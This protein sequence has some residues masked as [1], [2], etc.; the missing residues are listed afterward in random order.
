MIQPGNVF[1]PCPV[2]TIEV[3]MMCTGKHST[4]QI[5]QEV[6]RHKVSLHIFN[7]IQVLLAT[8]DWTDFTHC[9]LLTPCD[10]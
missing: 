9:G 1:V 4:Y 5:E 10:F 6:N 3:S 7:V 2:I 8:T